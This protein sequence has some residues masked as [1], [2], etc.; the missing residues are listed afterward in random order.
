LN[1][2]DR[3]YVPDAIIQSASA[4]YK[5]LDLRHKIN[6]YEENEAINFDPLSFCPSGSRKV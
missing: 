1:G 2:A 3:F 5:I 4:V 6:E